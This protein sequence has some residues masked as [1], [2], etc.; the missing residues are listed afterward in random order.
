VQSD[1]SS[2]MFLV[3]ILPPSAG[4]K[5]KS[6][7]WPAGNRNMAYSSTLKRAA[8]CSSEASVNFHRNTRRQYQKLLK[9]YSSVKIL[10]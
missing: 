3:N 1:S 2:Q 4:L 6:S 7:K 9:L 8:V 5:S 10:R